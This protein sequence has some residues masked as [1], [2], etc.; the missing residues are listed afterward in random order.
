MDAIVLDIGNSSVKVG[1]FKNAALEKKWTVKDLNDALLIIDSYQ[2]KHIAMCSVIQS[3]KELRN[4]LK[5]LDALILDKDTLVPIHNNYNTKE[6]LGVDRLA[7]VVGAESMGNESDTLI[8]DIGTCITYDLLDHNN[9]YHGG[10]ISPGVELRFKSMHDYTSKLPLIEDITTVDL[11]GKST[12]EAMIS[13]VIHGVTAEIDGVISQY[14]SKFPNLGV[15]VCGGGLFSFESK[16]KA[17]IFAAP[18]LVL[19]GLNRILEYNDES[20]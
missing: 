6:T 4:Q 1:A 18:D 8:I 11:V 14:Q 17:S 9:H 5:G 19:V 3:P 16:I 12:A 15:L 7:A 13:G 10:S 20:K 2:P